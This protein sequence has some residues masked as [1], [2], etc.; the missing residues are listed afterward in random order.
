M[1]WNAHLQHQTCHSTHPTRGHQKGF[2]EIT[3]SQVGTGIICIPCLLEFL[4]LLIG[5]FLSSPSHSSTLHSY[6]IDLTTL[7]LTSVAD[8]LLSVR[9]FNFLFGYNNPT[10]SIL[11]ETVPTCAGYDIPV[12]HMIYVGHTSKAYDIRRTY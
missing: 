1:C 5:H 2:Q 9:D 3:F 10:V 4:Y 12:K 7:D 8:Q 6:I 11:F